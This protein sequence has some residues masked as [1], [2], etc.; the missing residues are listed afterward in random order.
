MQTSKQEYYYQTVRYDLLNLIPSKNGNRILEIGAA[1]GNTLIAAKQM[2]LASEVCGIE[3][4]KIK[5]SNQNH[6]LI[7]RFFTGDIEQTVFDIEKEYFDVILAGEVLEH[8][9]DPWAVVAAYSQYLKKGGVFIASIPT[10]RSFTALKDIIFYGDFRYQHSGIFDRTHLRFFCRKNIIS[11]FEE[12]GLKVV[13]VISNIDMF[14]PWAKK[15]I[16]NALTFGIFEE[17]IVK[18]YDIVAQK[19]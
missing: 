17:F 2:G 13:K 19:C 8:L 10:I 11:L 9:C 3:L 14:K 7:D 1:G 12:N 15:R 5:N 16:L 4:V 6:P 18:K